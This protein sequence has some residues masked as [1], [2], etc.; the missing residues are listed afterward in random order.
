MPTQTPQVRLTRL[1][2]GSPLAGHTLTQLCLFGRR[3]LATMC[4]L[5]NPHRLLPTLFLPPALPNRVSCVTQP[6][7]SSCGRTWCS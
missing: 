4:A 3:C 7:R 5:P 1:C 6:T 2:S